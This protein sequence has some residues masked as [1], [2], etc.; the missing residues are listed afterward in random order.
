MVPLVAILGAGASRGSGFF[1]DNMPR[2]PAPE[3]PPLTVDLFNEQRYGPI[4][5][6][7]DLAHQAGRFIE[8][9]R[10]QDDALGLETVLH[11]LSNSDYQHH[12]HMALAV[13]PY[14]QHLLFAVSQGLYTGALHYDRLI[15]RL[16]CLPYVYFVSLNYDLLLDRRLN[17]HRPLDA[18]PDYISNDKNWAL[19][20]PHGSVNWYHDSEPFVP[21]KPPSNLS[22]NSGMFECTPPDAG[23]EEIRDLRRGRPAYS[24]RYPALAAPE[25]PDDRLVLPQAHQ[26]F[27]SMGLHRAQQIDILVIGYS[28][29]DDEV[30]RLIRETGTKLRHITVVDQNRETATAVLERITNAGLNPVW[31][32]ILD[33]DFASWS[34]DGGLTRLVDEY[35]GPYPR[36][37]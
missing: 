33:S 23:L 13:P 26:E 30:L 37:V 5:C 7:Y 20:K 24:N 17:A 27:F 16:L 22:W 9:E 14:L 19:I 6:E 29:L 10:A 3:V 34:S 8:Q 31:K 12:R 28:A 15:E 2:P 35:D 1:H 21:S 25:G 32:E 36:A 18:L 11:R 4:L